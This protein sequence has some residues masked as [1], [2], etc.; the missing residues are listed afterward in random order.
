MKLIKGIIIIILLIII[1]TIIIHVDA[2]GAAQ[3]SAGEVRVGHRSAAEA[4]EG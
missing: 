4:G 2:D 3:V 1:I